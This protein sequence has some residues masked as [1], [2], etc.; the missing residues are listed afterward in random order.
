MKKGLQPI[1]ERMENILRRMES[2]EMAI[3]HFLDEIKEEQPALFNYVFAED[4]AFLTDKEKDHLLFITA[5]LWTFRQIENP[6]SVDDIQH[7]EEAMWAEAEISDFPYSS[8]HPQIEALHD[9]L[10]AMLIDC[11]D[12]EDTGITPAGAR[13]LQVKGFTIAIILS[14]A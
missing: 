14:C 8:S 12:T 3:D 9:E 2:G 4:N 10:F 5:L 6:L 11:T 1:E 7:T 13:W